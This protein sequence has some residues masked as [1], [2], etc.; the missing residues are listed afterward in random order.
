LIFDK[1]GR[2]VHEPR[3]DDWRSVLNL[4]LSELVGVPKVAIHPCAFP[5]ASVEVGNVNNHHRLAVDATMHKL[6]H[7]ELV[8]HWCLFLS[9]FGRYGKA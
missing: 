4:I 2:A 7:L 8:C 1:F 9:I 6:T 3:D 5:T